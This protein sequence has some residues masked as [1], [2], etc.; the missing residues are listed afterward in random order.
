MLDDDLMKQCFLFPFQRNQNLPE[1]MSPRYGSIQRPQQSVSPM[2]GPV[3]SPSQLSPHYT[4]ST[5]NQWNA[6]TSQTAATL[7]GSLDRGMHQVKIFLPSN[8]GLFLQ[9]HKLK[10]TDNRVFSMASFLTSCQVLSF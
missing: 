10:R 3:S 9:F 7:Q 5:P 4:Q 6:R 2:V 8:L 1:P